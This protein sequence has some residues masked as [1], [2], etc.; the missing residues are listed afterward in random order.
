MDFDLDQVQLIVCACVLMMGRLCEPPDRV[1]SVVSGLPALAGFDS[2]VVATMEGQIRSALGDDVAAISTLRIAHL[3]L[4]RLGCLSTPGW[5]A[6]QLTAEIHALV[7]Q[8]SCAP[9]FMKFNPSVVAA[10]LLYCVRKQRGGVPAW[11]AALAAMTGYSVE[12]TPGFVLCVQLVDGLIASQ[13]SA[14]GN[15][16]ANNSASNGSGNGTG[17]A[18]NLPSAPTFDPAVAQ[19]T[20]QAMATA[21]NRR[22]TMG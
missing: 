6:D 3:Y 2:Q 19:A 20:S 13:A 22:V 7:V 5:Y 15:N 21:H 10:A 17:T 4:E 14:N 12:S 8:V 18:G 16:G 9:V 11:P 1:H